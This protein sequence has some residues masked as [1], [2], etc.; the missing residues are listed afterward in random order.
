MELKLRRR[1]PGHASRCQDA[2]SR[3]LCVGASGNERKVT[4]WLGHHWAT[5]RS[6]CWWRLLWSCRL[7]RR[8]RLGPVTAT[9]V[10]NRAQ[11]PNNLKPKTRWGGSDNLTDSNSVDKGSNKEAANGQ[12]SAAQNADGSQRAAEAPAAQE[13][14]AEEGA[15]ETEEPAVAAIGSVEYKTLQEAVDAQ[16]NGETVRLKANVTLAKAVVVPNRGYTISIN[17]YGHNIAS[18]GTAIKN[19]GVL[20][21]M[22]TKNNRQDFFLEKRCSCG[23]G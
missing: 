7:M 12:E 14:A 21:L 19:N 2:A 18:E 9:R 22:D 5:K 10:S 15:T 13:L 4:G 6:P 20:K 3:T 1:S 23:W 17:L 16:K 8:S 11:L